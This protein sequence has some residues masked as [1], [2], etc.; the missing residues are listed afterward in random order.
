MSQAASGVQAKAKK[1]VDAYKKEQDGEKIKSLSDIIIDSSE[2]QLA[3]MGSSY[4][5]NMLHGGGL[6]MGFGILTDKRF[7]FKGKCFK[8]VAVNNKMINEEYAVDLED[9]TATGFVFARS[10]LLVL[11]AILFGGA[12]CLIGTLLGGG[13]AGSFFVLGIAVA[14]LFLILYW[15]GKRAVYEA[16]F[17]GG[18]ICVDVSKYGGMKKVRAFNKK[19]RLAKDKKL[20]N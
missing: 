4:L 10:F 19:L 2:N 9:I 6:R 8:K 13:A 12:I 7:Y 14:V 5:D 11:Y 17:D 16:H 18:T 20:G 1:N 3:V 15:F